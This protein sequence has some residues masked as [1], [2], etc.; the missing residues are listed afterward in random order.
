MNPQ[1]TLRRLFTD[2]YEPI[3]ATLSQPE[4][5]PTWLVESAVLLAFTDA[6]R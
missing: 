4:R 5:W 3:K 1:Q 6:V 2:H